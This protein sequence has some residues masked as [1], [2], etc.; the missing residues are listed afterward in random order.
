ML[1]VMNGVWNIGTRPPVYS[2]YNASL[3]LPGLLLI[4]VR[5]T[6]KSLVHSSFA[7]LWVRGRELSYLSPPPPPPFPPLFLS[8]HFPSPL[9]LLSLSSFLH[10]MYHYT[11]YSTKSYIVD[12]LSADEVLQFVGRES[13]TSNSCKGRETSPWQPYITAHAVSWGARH[14]CLALSPFW[15]A[16]RTLGTR[17]TVVHSRKQERI[18]TGD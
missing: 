9:P 8:F 1:T 12:G 7:E 13:H 2:D 15:N 4:E 3:V 14:L 10:I 5:K 16:G 18:R 17:L 11:V 6:R